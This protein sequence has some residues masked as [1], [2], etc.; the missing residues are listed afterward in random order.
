MRTEYP[1]ICLKCRI[2]RRGWELMNYINSTKDLWQSLGDLITTEQCLYITYQF[3]LVSF[4]N[5]SSMRWMMVLKT[6][7][8]VVWPVICKILVWLHLFYVGLWDY[9]FN[10]RFF[11]Q[12]PFIT[13]STRLSCC[14]LRLCGLCTIED[15]K[16]VFKCTT[17][18][19]YIST[20]VR[21]AWTSC[22]L[23]I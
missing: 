11:D 8:S 7:V 21:G 20:V 15:L 6:S 18:M 14:S 4:N 13:H 3:H 17:G 16:D 9:C 2:F 12:P 19:E 10:L 22:Y 23:E 5:K 1:Q